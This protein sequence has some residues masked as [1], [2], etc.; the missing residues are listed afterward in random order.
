MK[1]NE[2]YLVDLSEETG[3]FLLTNTKTGEPTFKKCTSEEKK[4]LVS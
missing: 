4:K 3:N 2:Q 1:K